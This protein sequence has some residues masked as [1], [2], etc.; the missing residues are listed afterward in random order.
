M[1]KCKLKNA[2]CPAVLRL[3]LRGRPSHPSEATTRAVFIH[4]EKTPTKKKHT[5]LHSIPR[6]SEKTGYF[7]LRNI[8]E[9]GALV[10]HLM[11]PLKPPQ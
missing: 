9:A 1:K 8:R 6:P 10:P 5:H 7:V 11:A 3:P 2:L 4:P